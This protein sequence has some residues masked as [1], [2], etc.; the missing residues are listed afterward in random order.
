M[1]KYLLFV[2]VFAGTAI[3]NAQEG[4]VKPGAGKFSVEVGFS[5]LGMSRS[6]QSIYLP[7]GE[8]TGHYSITNKINVR[9]GLGVSY[10]YSSYDNGEDK[11]NGWWY[12]SSA[13]QTAISLAPGFSY[14][15][16]GT[17]KMTP[18]AGAEFRFVTTCSKQKQETI[19][20]SQTQTNSDYVS[21]S[22]GQ[23]LP[24]NGY[25]V[26]LFTGFNYYFVKNIYLGA[27]V[28]LG[29][30]YKQDKQGVTKQSDRE[31]VKVEEKRNE[32]G[33]NLYA[34]PQIRLGWAF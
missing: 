2:L 28:G 14:S 17:K 16:G 33:L 30:L 26:N 34:N 6:S 9:L 12:K 23:N 27:E 18:Y 21:S 10:A 19:D 8:L 20:E 25:G 13:S 32:L 24:F 15:F 3:A 7:M 31:D 29:F 11:E 4:S 1:R 22:Y 5:P